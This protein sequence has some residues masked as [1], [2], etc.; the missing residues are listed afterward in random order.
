MNKLFS[1]SLITP[2]CLLA[3]GG[4]AQAQSFS[5]PQWYTGAALGRAWSNINKGDYTDQQAGSVTS[6]N[7]DQGTAWK[8]YGGYQF[9]QNWGME[10]GYTS[11]GRYNS[12]YGLASTGSSATGSNRLSAW[13]LAGVGTLPLSRGFSLAGKAG[14]A[15]LRNEY[16]FSGLGSSYLAGDNGTARDV[17]LLLGV[18]AKYDIN[19]NLAIR[20][21]YENYG[22]VG[23]NTNGLSTTGATGTA[24]PSMVSAGVQY[25]F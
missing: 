22:K 21:D 18:G 12:N 14:L 17:G 6:F 5:G 15:L 2:A 20:F 16:T 8:L 9:T 19:R 7:T 24:R 25:N 23:N 10:L 3:F 13:S 4:S 1:L 11:L